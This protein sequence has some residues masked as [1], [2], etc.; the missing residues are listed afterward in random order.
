MNYS[1][2]DRTEKRSRKRQ[3]SISGS[4]IIPAALI[5]CLFLAGMAW[6]LMGP[7]RNGAGGGTEEESRPQQES[8]SAAESTSAE[9]TLE[10]DLA[11]IGGPEAES[12]GPEDRGDGSPAAVQIP[13]EGPTAGQELEELEPSDEVTLGFAG[14]IYFSD[15]VLQAYDGAGYAGG[16]LDDT[17]MEAIKDCSFF[18]AN[19]EFPF[20]AGGQK[21]K[22]KQFTFRISPDRVHILQEIGCDCVTLANN[23]VLDYGAE[24]LA[25]NNALL[26]QAGIPHTGAGAGLAEAET[27]VILESDGRTIGILAGSRVYPD[28]GWAAGATHPGVLSAYDPGRLIQDIRKA[29]ETCDYVAVFIHWGVEKKQTPE[30]YQ[31]EMGRKFIDAGADIVVGSHPHVLQGIEY[32][33]GKPILYSMGNFIF[34]SSIPETMMGRITFHDD[35]KTELQVIPAK[36]S[37]GKTGVLPEAGR[38]A[39]FQKLQGLSFGVTIDAEGY[40]TPVQQ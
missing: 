14:D 37:G 3:N 28:A 31:K 15:Y 6:F 12:T 23:H 34:N 35:G 1:G 18:A 36:A 24:A 26:D 4:P 11:D 17:L 9:G 32:Y 19:Q 38:E 33:D 39:F 40:V 5:V 27:P 8:E 21:A 22:D 29:K 10:D 20:A 7:G 16:I 30:N 13:G 25:E 2:D